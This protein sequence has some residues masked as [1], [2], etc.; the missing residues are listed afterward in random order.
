MSVDNSHLLL[1]IRRGHRL[2]R[3]SV[4]ESPR[5]LIAEVVVD[6]S[7]PSNTSESEPPNETIQCCEVCETNECRYNCPRCGLAY[8]SV[9][10]YNLHS[11]TAP[12]DGDDSSSRAPAPLCT[13]EFYKNRV[14]SVLKLELKSE[15]EKTKH[16]LQRQIDGPKS[17]DSS[18]ISEADLYEALEA[19]AQSSSRGGTEIPDLPPVV[20]AA[21]GNAL[22]SGELHELGLENWHPWWLPQL[23]EE[24][25]E[26]DATTPRSGLDLDHAVQATLDE[27]ILNIPDFTTIKKGPLP[28]LQYNLAEILYGYAWASR[29]YC[30]LE[31]AKSNEVVE[32][33]YSTIMLAS[34]VLGQDAR[35]E[36]I[37]AVLLESTAS[38][39]KAYPRECNT[40]WKVLVEDVSAILQSSR[41]VAKSLLEIVDLLDAVI[42]SSKAN[43]SDKEQ[44]KQARRTK[45]KVE[46]FLSWAKE[47]DAF[48]DLIDKLR[49]VVGRWGHRENE[50]PSLETF[51]L[52]T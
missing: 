14:S 6:D 22:R 15:A 28:S 4:D 51:V 33:A 39:T 23:L 24:N 25:E 49:E 37:E 30:G 5:P 13:E 45:K 52:P 8:C 11:A 26:M 50:A 10:C 12:L 42:A 44:L 31:F 17:N 40:S 29:L 3:R 16:M 1:P 34:R 32:E 21:F 20:K 43:A 36:S 41:F 19:I 9:K 2:D 27:R 47:K 48:V 7:S 46:F 35:Y 38:S 18:L